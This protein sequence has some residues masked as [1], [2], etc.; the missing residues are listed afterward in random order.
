MC[1]TMKIYTLAHPITKEVRYVGVTTARLS[2]RLAQHIWGAR[3]KVSY[4]SSWIKK[5]IDLTG[6]Y[7]I[8]E[9]VEQIDDTDWEWIER[10]WISQFKQWGFN[11]VNT[12]KG[13]KGVCRNVEGRV[14]T[15]DAHKKP[16]YQYNLDGTFVQEWSSIREA[17]TFYAGTGTAIYQCSYG[18]SKTSH[19]F[20][21]SKIKYDILPI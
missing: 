19:G 2:Q 13:G 3:N 18:S 16:L 21:W 17:N 20:R 1:G 14:R 9:L 11:L 10:Y 7:P 6:Q 8:I 5:T 12:D 4:K 15:I